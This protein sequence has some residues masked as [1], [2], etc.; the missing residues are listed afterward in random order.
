MCVLVAYSYIQKNLTWYVRCFSKFLVYWTTT[1]THVVPDRQ[2]YDKHTPI[3]TYKR[4]YDT[5]CKYFI[6]N[7]SFNEYS[8][9]SRQPSI[10]TDYSS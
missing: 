9:T 7:R 8:T 2:Q 1:S 5:W 10:R 4:R 6:L 3:S